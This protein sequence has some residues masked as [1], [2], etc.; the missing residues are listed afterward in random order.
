[1]KRLFIALAFG[2]LIC[3]TGC[4]LSENIYLNEDGSGKMEF[5][6]DGSQLMTMMGDEMQK[7]GEE[8]IDSVFSFKELMETYKDS[9][10]QLPAAEQEKLKSLQKLTGR[11][12][13]DP[14]EGTF[15]VFLMTDFKD[16]NE[17]EDMFSK[18]SDLQGLSKRAK[19]GSMPGM[20]TS[21]AASELAYTFKGKKFTRKTTI[22][23]ENLLKSQLDSISD[24][25]SMFEGS[26]YTLNY[27]FPKKVKSVSIDGAVISEDGKTVTIERSFSEYLTDP[28]KLDV[29]IKLK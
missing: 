9:I 19:G 12:I 25:L 28:K 6:F 3:L 18:M 24:M 16:V 2:L 8:R 5:V 27:H 23:D 22:I 7:N 13:M 20:A 14:K 29:E 15:N 21:G 26:T 10:A 4:K 11:M 1:M 17:L